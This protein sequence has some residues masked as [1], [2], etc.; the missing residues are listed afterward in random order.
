MVERV[1]DKGGLNEEQIFAAEPMHR[2]GKPEEIAE[3]VLGLCSEASSFVTGLPMPIDGGYV[4]LRDDGAGSDCGGFRRFARAGLGGRFGAFLRWGQ[5]FDLARW[6]AGL[7]HPRQA[8]R[9][10][11]KACN[12]D[13]LQ[14]FHRL[15]PMVLKN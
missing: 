14:Y 3:A 10:N 15:P 6:R 12:H 9:S 7:C 11:R 5:A 4:A 8:Q 1:L 2:M 13:C